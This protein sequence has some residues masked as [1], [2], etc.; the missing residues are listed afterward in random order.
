MIRPTWRA[1]TAHWMW[2]EFPVWVLA[3]AAATA[4]LAGAIGLGHY[5]GPLLGDLTLMQ[6]TIPLL[7]VI[8]VLLAVGVLIKLLKMYGSKAVDEPYLTWIVWLVIVATAIWLL[9]IVGVLD[10]FRAVP[11]PT[12]RK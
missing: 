4:C 3:Y 1:K 6:G 2:R 12:L 9:N 7:T 11:M 10:Y 8:L 5:L